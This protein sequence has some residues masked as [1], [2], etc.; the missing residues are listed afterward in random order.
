V[1]RYEEEAAWAEDA[2]GSLL[3]AIRLFWFAWYG[4]HPDTEVFTAD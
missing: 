3:P 1:V 2:D 4:F